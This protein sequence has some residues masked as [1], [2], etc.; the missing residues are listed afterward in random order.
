MKTVILL[1]A[2]ALL[3]I[4][5]SL[6]AKGLSYDNDNNMEV[7]DKKARMFLRSM[8]DN[9]DDDDDDDDNNSPSFDTREFGKNCVRCKFGINPCCA[10][11]RC[12]KKFLRPDECVE[13]KTGK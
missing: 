3:L 7:S 11:N 6:D 13:V 12:K 4:I 1:G 10:P 8:L 9:D 5:S 2:F